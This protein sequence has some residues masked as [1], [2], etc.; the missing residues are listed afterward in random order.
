MQS[1]S[2]FLSLL[3]ISLSACAQT[4]PASGGVPAVPAVAATQTPQLGMSQLTPQLMY[5]FLLGEI[6]GQRGELRLS[7]EAYANLA[8]RARDVRI[9]RRATEVALYARQGGLA[10]RNAKLWLE[11]EPDSAQARQTLASLLVGAGKLAEAKPSLEAWIRSGPAEKV[12]TQLHSLFARQGDKA[13][14]LGLVTDLAAAY[15]AL[16]EARFA[17]AQAAWQA[18]QGSNA[19][20]ALEDVLKLKPDWEYAALFKAQVLQQT[21][22]D[23][24]AIAFLAE[25]LKSQPGAREVR[26]AYAKQLARGGRLDEARQVF[27]ALAAEAPDNPEPH[28]A[29]G[30]VAMQANDMETARGSFLKALDLEHA[31]KGAAQ[32]FLGQIA[33][34]QAQYEEA[35]QR[36][37]A[38]TGPQSFDA[39][40]RVAAVLGKLGRLDEARAGLEDMTATNENQGVRLAQAEAELLREARQ[41]APAMQVFEAALKRYPDNL[42]LLYDR[43]MVAEKLN[44]LDVLEA[45]LRRMIE[46]KP[47]YA[48]AYNALGYTLADRTNRLTEA[49]ALLE[50]A[51]NLAPDDPFIQDSMG[52]ALF[53]LKRYTEAADYLRRAYAA[54]PDP[55]IAAHL[56]EVL[57]ISGQ[58]DEARR[59]WQGGLKSHPDNESLRETLSRLMP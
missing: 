29:L 49:V 19:L 46:L 34:A 20:L 26:L 47:D 56:G 36:Y 42:E 13:A 43:A 6:A 2:L 23:E 51:L 17:V 38:V 57:W 4:P 52:W 3:T 33:E 18:G 9:A 1:K 27:A 32:Y 30:L 12:F 41:Y 8:G 58:R 22:G 11:L 35:M 44:R 39:G 25:Y 24:D 28:F 21:R 37:Q 53:K 15:P 16:P 5:E 10:L 7:A 31:D 48:H 59:I 14:V 45:D 55:E 40:L 50:K 54:R